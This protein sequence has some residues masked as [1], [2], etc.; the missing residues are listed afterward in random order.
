MHRMCKIRCWTLSLVMRKLGRNDRI[1][2]DRIL[3]Y[4]SLLTKLFSM[5][6]KNTSLLVR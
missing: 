3:A 5:R 1:F 4:G 6:F 2:R